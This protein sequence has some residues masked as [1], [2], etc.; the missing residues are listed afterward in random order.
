MNN[1]SNPQ[2][3]P[4]SLNEEE[5]TKYLQEHLDFF[6]RHEDLLTDL[7]LPHRKAGS[8]SLVER[9]ISKLRQKNTELETKLRDLVSVARGND[10]L[11]T[12]IHAFAMELLSAQDPMHKFRVLEG[13]LSNSFSAENSILVLFEEKSNEFDV[14]DSF[15]IYINR[16]DTALKPFK[17]FMQSNEPRCGLIRKSQKDFLFASNNEICSV[18][19]I[20]LGEECCVGFLAIG[21]KDAERFNPSKGLDFLSRLGDLIGSA[22]AIR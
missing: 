4:D 1:L 6:E 17:T 19:L 8:V 10:E 16:N 11:S 20:P 18:A 3:M 22:L 14:N 12:K 21:S 9:Q 15:L 13:L 7:R 5:V 2:M